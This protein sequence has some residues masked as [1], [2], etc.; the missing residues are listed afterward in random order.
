MTTV[1]SGVCDVGTSQC[2][3][4]ERGVSGAAVRRGHMRSHPRHLYGCHTRLQ[5]CALLPSSKSAINTSQVCYCLCSVHLCHPPPCQVEERALH[6]R[7]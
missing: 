7:A 2:R 3:T 4:E 6:G 1:V 5:P